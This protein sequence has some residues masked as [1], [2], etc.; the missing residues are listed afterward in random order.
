MP[1]QPGHFIVFEGLD[2]AGTT[3]QANRLHQYF[4][5][6]GKNSFATYEPTDGPIGTF[7]RRVLTGGMRMDE[8]PYRP[9]GEHAMALLFAADRL[10]HS[11]QINTVLGDGIDV[12]CDRYIYSTLAYQTLDESVSPEWIVETNRGCSIPQ[13]T[14][15]LDVPVDVCLDRIA[16]RNESPSI[17]EK[18]DFLKTIKQ[19]YAHLEALYTSHFGPVV[20]IDGTMSPDDVHAAIVAT[21]KSTK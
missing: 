12:L 20:K 2:G 17:Y 9:A 6:N 7:I 15:F 21:I 1:H 13:L 18:K 11:Q 5:Q 10:A 3:T 4:T 14:I 16:S 19:N 8:T